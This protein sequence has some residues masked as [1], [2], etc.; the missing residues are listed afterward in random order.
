MSVKPY[1]FTLSVD[2]ED[3][4]LRGG[5]ATRYGGAD[6]GQDNGEGAGGFN[7]ATLPLPRL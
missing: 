3:L 2:G 1:N 5:S 4:V 6:D 7:T